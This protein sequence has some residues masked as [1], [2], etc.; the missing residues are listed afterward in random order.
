M[1]TLDERAHRN[2]ADFYRWMPALGPDVALLDTDGVVGLATPNDWP[3]DRLALREDR[4]VAADV[5]VDRVEEFLGARGRTACVFARVDVDDDIADLLTEK[6][7]TEYTRTPEMV[8]SAALPEREPGDGVGVRLAET[9]EDV[10]AYAAIAAKAFT[11]LGLLED[12][13]R[14][15]LD[16]PD[17]LLQPD[18]AVSLAEVDGTPVA[19]ALSV[20]VGAERN[21]YVGWVACLPEG[22]GRQLGDLVTRLVTNEAFA[23]G[24]P[25]VTL[26]ASRFGESTYRRMGYEERYRYRML[27]KL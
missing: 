9:A 7:Y 24:A 8:C 26:E 13:L 10:A 17:A 5:F 27:I 3:S 25:I 23:R 1:A 22:R 20:L 14:E 18:V 16:A 11:D 19:G 15:L 21:G 6:G 2:L 4:S 12:P